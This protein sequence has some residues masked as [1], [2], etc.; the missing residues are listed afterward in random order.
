MV[1]FELQ[2]WDHYIAFII[3]IDHCNKSAFIYFILKFI[4]DVDHGTIY[5]VYCL[6]LYI[7]YTV[8]SMIKS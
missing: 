2:S 4:L 5:R 1:H 8:F 7:I 6:K 3:S